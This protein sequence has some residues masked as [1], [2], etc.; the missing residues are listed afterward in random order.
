METNHKLILLGIILGHFFELL[1]RCLKK[2]IVTSIDLLIH[3]KNTIPLRNLEK[4]S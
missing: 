1:A 2:E 3:S 4:K